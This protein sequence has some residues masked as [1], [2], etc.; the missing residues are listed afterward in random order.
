MNFKGTR[1]RSQFDL[2]L[3]VENMGAHLN[4]YTSREQT[5]YFAKCFAH[6]T[7][8]AVEILSDILLNSVYGSR[9][10]ENER[11]VIL[12]EM[13]EVEQ[14]MQEVVFDHL[15]AGAYNG[16]SL[17]GTI[18][19]PIENIKSLNRNDMLDYIRTFYKGQRMVLCGAGGVEHEQL[20]DFAEKYFGK[21]ERGS[22][23]VLKYEP[24]VFRNSYQI[25][26]NKAMEQIYGCLSVEGTSWTHPDN[27][28][29]QI[30]NV[31][32]GSYDRTQS[33]GVAGLTLLG[34]EVAKQDLGVQSFMSFT[35]NYKD[36]GLTGTYFCVDDAKAL[37][38]F[39]KT[40]TSVWKRLCH[41]VDERKLND[42][43]RTIFLNMLLMLDGSTPICEDIGRYF[44]LIS[45]DYF[46]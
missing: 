31:M 5:T 19:G 14:N 29:T 26:P 3:E 36:T 30:V 21:I 34:D 16:C 33:Q 10:I 44:N 15:H 25:F 38:Q 1:K 27:I 18:L 24:G 45:F 42:A 17:S 35:T 40:I 37:Q 39:T 22:A 11:G 43:K 4:A 8:K 41:E 12:R 32:L 13:Q 6:D 7:E 28:A 9:E 2:E 46:N 20:V 23:E